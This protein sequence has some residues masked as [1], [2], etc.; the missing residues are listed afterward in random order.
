MICY[1]QAV[2]YVLLLQC[3]SKGKGQLAGDVAEKE[4]VLTTTEE[5]KRFWHR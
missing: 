4:E 2:I 1:L 5:C 3:H